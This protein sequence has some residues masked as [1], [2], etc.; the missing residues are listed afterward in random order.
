MSMPAKIAP[1]G[2]V[3]IF[4][5]GLIG[6]SLARA[7]RRANLA[8]EILGFARRPA[9]LDHARE[10][11]VIDRGSLDAAAIAAVADVIVLATPVET[12]IALLRQIAPHL[13]P[14]ALV[15]DVGS[16]KR[17][18]A[19]AAREIF[20]ATA[21]PRVLPGHPMA[22]REH[23]GLDYATDDLFAN[24]VWLL[25]PLGEERTAAQQHF[26][27]VLEAL[28]AR[29]IC[30]T[31]EEHDRTLA[32]TSHLPQMMSTALALTV[33]RAFAHDDRLLGAHAGGLRSMLR[34]AA[35]DPSMWEQIAS[36][37]P[38]NIA[39]A[40][41]EAESALRTLREELTQPQFR[42]DFEQARQLAR[43]LRHEGN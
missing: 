23:S 15:S 43:Q 3:A 21:A 41:A 38:D 22:G 31:P 12:S 6:G 24:A 33:R 20:G 42:A 7:L 39:A 1:L 29:L 40:L 35:S 11:N 36:S 34:L 2:T 30:C 18:F 37:N 27:A 32:Y 14:Q 26:M 9:L 28:G 16:T 25:T 5:L 19:A 13:K 4:G 17:A 10:L 8:H